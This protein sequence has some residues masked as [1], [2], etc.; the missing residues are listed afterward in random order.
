MENRALARRAGVN[1]PTPN[2]VIVALQYVHGI[3]PANGESALAA[4]SGIIDINSVE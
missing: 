3:G 4:V 1:M 2:R